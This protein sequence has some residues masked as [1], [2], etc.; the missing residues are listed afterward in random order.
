MKQYV[1]IFNQIRSTSGRI[2]KEELLKEHENVEG[3]KEILKFVYNT[4]ITSGIAK[5]KINKQLSLSSTVQLNSIFDCIEYVKENN[6]G[7]DEIIANLQNYLNTLDEEE[8]SL[9]IEILTKDLPIGLSRTTL[10]KVY[11]SNFIPKYSVMLA[12]KYEPGKTDLSEGFALTLKIDGNR[13]TVFNYESGPVFYARSGKEIEGLS[14][15][16]EAFKTLP[17]NMVYDG[18]L[19]ASNKNIPTE[20]LFRMTQTI[21]RK[22]GEKTGLEF[23][24]FD[25][26]PISEFNE[27]KSKDNYS[28]RLEKMEILMNDYENDL[29]KLVPIYYVGNDEEK[30]QSVLNEV[31]ELGYEGLMLNLLNSKYETKRIKGLLKIKTFYTMDLVV[32]AVNEEVRGG[33][34]GSLS[35]DYQGFNVNVP[36]L[37]AE[38]QKRFWENP[39]EIIGRVIEVK[40]FEESENAEEGKSLRFPSFVRVRSDKDLEDVSYA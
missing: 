37:K 18:E 34:C 15:M 16:A 10:N 22:K 30:I 33:K 40:Y 7:T 26:L 25:M 12:N 29:I 32:T 23:I 20:E 38:D 13:A 24:L 11:G 27:G 9:A 1:G 28:L 31:D 21:I 36:I 4:L 19:I 17:K 8:K 2:A 39:S 14:E 3:F 6:T 35:V 5:K